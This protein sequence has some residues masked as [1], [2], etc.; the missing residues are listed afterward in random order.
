[1]TEA[2]IGMPPAATTAPDPAAG[3][4]QPSPP[5]RE[6]SPPPPTRRYKGIAIVGSN[7]ITKFLAPFDD[8]DWLIW[9]CSPA[10]SPHGLPSDSAV[11][12]RWDAWFELHRPVA[13]PTRPFGY[14]DWL[15]QNARVIYIR[16]EMAKPF[17]P[18][19]ILYPEA[20]MKKEFGPFLFQSSINYMQALAIFEC[21]R[22]DIPMIALH[23]ILQAAE[24]EYRNHRLA[25]QQFMVEARRRGIQTATPSPD[26]IRATDDKG[27]IRKEFL[28]ARDALRALYSPPPED[29]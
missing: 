14:L 8:P 24:T 11:I 22:L 13:H 21:L 3:E 26:A 5:T 25:T 9:A 20:A 23:G 28:Y 2:E 7:P 15:R 19:A 1:M 10:N 12:P 18:G 6:A 16:D 27:N 4:A 29:W 17:F